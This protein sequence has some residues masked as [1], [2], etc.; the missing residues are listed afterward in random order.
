MKLVL[1]VETHQDF[2]DSQV[3]SINKFCRKYNC[4]YLENLNNKN[5]GITQAIPYCTL[6]AHGKAK[7]LESDLMIYVGG[8]YSEYN[9]CKIHT[10][11]LWKVGKDQGKFID[12]F[13]NLDSVFDMGFDQFLEKYN[14]NGCSE[15]TSFY[16]LVKPIYDNEY[17]IQC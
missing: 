5:Q 11:R 6:V 7:C 10:K 15:D 2:Y 4:I 8:P 17:L 9:I 16:D 12:P 3:E 1:A 14:D 13:K